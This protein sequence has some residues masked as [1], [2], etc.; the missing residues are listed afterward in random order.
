[1]TLPPDTHVCFICP[2]IEPYLRPGSDTTVGGA[3]RQQHLLASELRDSGHEVSFITFE[4]DGPTYERIDGFD[5]W[6]TL[7]QTNALE[8]APMALYK[9]FRSIRRVD[10]DL[11]Y[12]RGNPPLCIMA[13]YCCAL[14][15]EP[16]VYAVANDSNV[17]LSKLSD[18]HGAFSHTVP[19]LG[20]LDA[21]RRAN[22][23][24]AQTPYQHSVLS[25]VFGIDATTIPNGYTLPPE[26][27]IKPANQRTHVLW[28]G[29]FDPDQKRPDRF[30]DLAERLPDVQFRLIGSNGPPE[31]EQQIRERAESLPNLSDEGFVPPDEIDQYY[32]DA[33]AFVNTSEY[34]GFPNTYLEA[35]RYG[36][37][38]VSLHEMLDGVVE[39]ERIGRHAGSMDELATIVEELWADRDRASDL[40]QRG[41]THVESEYAMDAVAEKY[42]NVFSD[43]LPG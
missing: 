35:W 6:R 12:A 18:H 14:L 24:V 19:K 34:E 37:P 2:Y 9:V 21:I 32:R 13:S 29:S 17:E 27:E 15:D 3:E 10:A 22:G 1:M 16:L 4:G 43:V 30:L 23:V 5:C 7:P 28:V 42:R 41:R 20:Y 40:G 11:Y 38:V 8:H 39:R 33:V 36:V 31:Y 25:D 26:R